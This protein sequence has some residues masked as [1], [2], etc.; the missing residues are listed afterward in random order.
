[1][2]YG[3]RY[4]IWYDMIYDVCYMIWHDISYGMPYYF[5][6]D[7][8]WC[9]MIYDIWY[10]IIWYYFKLYHMTSYDIIW[11]DAISYVIIWYYMT[12]HIM[13]YHIIPYHHISYVLSGEC[14]YIV[15][16]FNRFVI[17]LCYIKITLLFSPS[18]IIGTMFPYCQD[19][20][21]SD[22]AGL[23]LINMIHNFCCVIWIP[24]LG[25]TIKT[26]NGSE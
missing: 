11:Y 14:M 24:C 22:E 25:I 21:L 5:S 13:L 2:R 26:L 6:Y 4:M 1:M 15:F 23:D 7:V 20:I 18:V 3:M 17:R 8:M 19:F 10:N 12:W 9:D 16:C